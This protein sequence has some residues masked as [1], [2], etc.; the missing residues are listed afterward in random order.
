M[1]L[2]FRDRGGAN[3]TP[4]GAAGAGALAFLLLLAVGCGEAEPGADAAKDA[5]KDAANDVSTGADADPGDADPGADVDPGE[6]DDAGEQDAGKDSRWTGQCAAGPAFCDDGNPCTEDRCDPLTGCY[7]EPVDCADEDPCTV[8]GCDV[9]VGGCTHGTNDCEDGNLCTKG[10]CQAGIGCVYGLLDCSDGDLCTADGCSPVAGCLHPPLTCD[11]GITCTVDAC[12][13]Q[14]G[15]KH[16][17]P[18]GALCCESV[19]DCEDQNVCTQHACVGGACKDLP[20]YGCCQ[21]DA[22]CDDEN[23]CTNDKCATA[24][25]L[26][27]HPFVPGP[28]CCQQHLECDDGVICTYDRCA[29]GQC[30]H[31][32]Q[33]CKNASD[34][35]LADGATCASASCNGASC[36]YSPKAG[37]G[38][39]TPQLAETDFEPGDALV[40]TLAPSKHG[41]FS[42]GAFGPDEAKAGAQSLRYQ[43]TGATTAGGQPL[44]EARLPKLQLPLGL[45]PTLTF[46]YRGQLSGGSSGDVFRLRADTSLGSVYLW[47][48]PPFVGWTQVT[49]NLRGFAARPATQEVRLVFEVKPGATVWAGSKFWLDSLSVITSCQAPL[50]CQADVDCDDGLGATAETCA[51]GVCSSVT[52]KLYCE[53]PTL[54]NDNNACT[55]D[56]CGSNFACNHVPIPNCCTKTADCE[57]SNPCTTDVCSG[58]KCLHIKK[59]GSACCNKVADCDDSNPCTLDACPSVGLPCQWTKT[60]ASCCISAADCDDSQPCTLD[61]CKKNVCGHKSQCCQGPSECD[62][63]DECTDNACLAGI[64]GFGPLQKPGC[65]V[66]EVASLGFEDGS[67]GPLV[68]ASQFQTSQWQVVSGKQAKTGKGALYYGNPTK[69]NFDDGATGGQVTWK[70]LKLEAGEGHQVRVWL[71]MDTEAGTSYDRF[72]VQAIVGGVGIKLWDKASLGFELKNWVEVKLNLSAFAG[73]T[74]DLVFDFQ[75]VDSVANNGE[76]VYLDDLLLTRT[77]ATKAC[78]TAKECDDD[79]PSTADT[80][81]NGSCAYSF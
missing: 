22:D 44:A 54:C 12:D 69:G 5:S 26:C 43:V 60:D 40:P 36:A 46:W 4:S 25:G 58:L 81:I 65:C 45:A 33:C 15:C 72:T 24:I 62:D 2:R 77:C 13:P 18:E 48:A 68:L 37:S 28:G 17:A 39:C 38:C 34:C 59:P 57:D 14:S 63:G 23:P 32:V 6:V 64:C 31:E 10:V 3:G 29:N 76:G 78:N 61:T 71:W 35:G 16:T 11:D 41:V 42:I 19:A 49:I 1:T 8:D 70:G 74:I 50:P 67:T 75:T 73:K 21:K 7:S 80:C 9:Q 20:V 79:Q 27:S 66:P 47:Q 52:S 51:G 30:G 55:L 56:S 53:L